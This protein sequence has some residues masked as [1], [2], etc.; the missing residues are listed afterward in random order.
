MSTVVDSK[1]SAGHD[2][3]VVTPRAYTLS[4]LV[5]ESGFDKRTIAYYVQESLLPKVGRRGRGTRYSQDFAD[6]L[7]FI[8]R[9][10]DL[11]DAG[12]LRAVTLGEIRDVMA[13]LSTQEVRG[14]S[15]KNVAADR[16]RALFEDPDLDNVR[17]AVRAEDVAAQE[18]LRASTSAL[19]EREPDESSQFA[20][21]LEA[22]TASRAPQP[23]KLGARIRELLAKIE[24]HARRGAKQSEGTGREH[25]TRVRVSDNVH[26]S[27]TH[28]SEDDAELVEELA[29]LLREKRDGG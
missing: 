22:S 11:Q 29:E 4:E 21:V 27:V 17:Y 18:V 8:R 26:L 24:G 23:R 25:L 5:E 9:V 16:I 19:V 13:A 3:G 15:R 1:R 10:R 2:S 20:G 14:L 28:L 6:R 7:L 12:Q